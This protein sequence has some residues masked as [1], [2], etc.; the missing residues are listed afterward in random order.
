MQMINTHN[1]EKKTGGVGAY[2]NCQ[3]MH[4][5]ELRVSS[6][7]GEIRNTFSVLLM[8][9][10]ITSSTH[11]PQPGRGLAN[12]SAFIFQTWEILFI[13]CK[14]QLISYLLASPPRGEEMAATGKV[15]PRPS[16]SPR[17]QTYSYLQALQSNKHIISHQ[18]MLQHSRFL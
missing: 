2:L 16:I 18:V 6:L 7:A 9:Q 11:V 15:S 8:K 14:N 1:G 10:Y 4:L 3:I 17:F 12:T 13:K 5:N